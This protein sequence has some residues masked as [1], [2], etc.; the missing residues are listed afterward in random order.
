MGKK[1]S[2]TRQE[3]KWRRAAGST[4]WVE[5]SAGPELAAGFGRWG[6]GKFAGGVGCG[7][8]GCADVTSSCHR[9]VDP[10]PHVSGSQLHQGIPSGCG[11]SEAGSAGFWWGPPRQ[12]REPAGRCSWRGRA[13]R[14]LLYRW[15][16]GSLRVGPRSNSHWS[17]YLPGL[18]V[19]FD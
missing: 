14:Q 8:R 13:H 18:K 15:R 7:G 5:S 10:I 1:S 6:E 12:R 19:T 11:V 4:A 16:A 17:R 9:H 3:S 2:S